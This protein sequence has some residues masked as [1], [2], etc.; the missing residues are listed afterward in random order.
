VSRFIDYYT[1][2]HYAECYYA[3]CCY[4]E[5][6]YAERRYAECR[7]AECRY[8]EC[9]YAECR[10]ALCR[11]LPPIAIGRIPTLD[12]NIMDIVSYHFTTLTQP[13]PYLAS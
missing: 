1:K 5:C 8:A 6:R 2:S 9:R 13:F 11:F 3:E 7:Y 4:A 12:F 10:G